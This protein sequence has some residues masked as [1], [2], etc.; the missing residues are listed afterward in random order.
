[1]HNRRYKKYQHHFDT[2]EITLIDVIK[3][4]IEMLILSAN[5]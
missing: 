3:K 1:M 4:D 2:E 5:F